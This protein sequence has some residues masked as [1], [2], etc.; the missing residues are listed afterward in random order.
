MGT[1][2]LDLGIITSSLFVLLIAPYLPITA[3]LFRGQQWP[4]IVLTAMVMGCSIQAFI[5]L[6]WSHLVKI[7][8]STEVAILAAIWLMLMIWSIVR[9]RRRRAIVFDRQHYSEHLGLIFIL[10]AGFIVRSI[11]PLQVGYLGQSDAYTHLNYVR[12]IIDLGYLINPMYPPGYHWIM[13]LPSLVLAIDPYQTVR[14][15]GALFG[16][17]LVLA[18]YVL[19]D[20]TVSRRAAQFGSFCAAAFPGMNLLMKTGVGAFANQFGLLLVPVVLLFYILIVTGRGKKENDSIFL[21]ISSCGLAAAVPMMLIHLLLIIGFERLVML[22]SNRRRWPINTL[23]IAGLLLPALLLFTFHI[24]HVGADQR[25]RTAEMM[26]SY[27]GKKNTAIEVIAERVEQKISQNKRQKWKIASVVVQSP[28]FK[29]L[30]DYSSVKRKGFGNLKIDLLA[31]VLAILFLILLMIGLLRKVNSYIVLGLWGLLTNIQAST[32]FLQFSSYQREGWSLLIATCC[33]S[34]ILASSAYR[35]VEHIRLF[36]MAV[37]GAMAAS[38]SWCVV[39]PPFHFPIWSSAEN[40]LV[41]TIRSLAIKPWLQ[42][43]VCKDTKT[44]AICDIVEMLDPN[45]EVT[46]V[47][48]RFVGWGNQ[49]EIAL[50]VVP[51]G[52]PM[53]VLVVDN[54]MNNEVFQPGRQYVVLV[55]V[56]N[57]LSGRQMISA[58]AMVTPYMLRVTLNSRERLFKLNRNIVR[59]LSDLDDSSWDVKHVQVSDTLSAYV[60]VPSS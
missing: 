3:M 2:L 7:R 15:G 48:R 40:E 52:S 33:L 34:G 10:I 4:K 54:N 31:L 32:G 58:F 8:P 18:I 57:R 30:S 55:D 21:T 9:S 49:G 56:K 20:Q 39:H 51:Y 27:S 16:T 14:F 23:H 36:R 13:A 11:H 22:I 37:I 41:K 59:N 50:N 60:V 19:L 12:N 1:E 43:D 24:G 53:P 17:A 45:F 42:P 44:E 28:Y 5:G 35:F 25:F 6:L 46:L 38:F 26:T 47:T 29:L